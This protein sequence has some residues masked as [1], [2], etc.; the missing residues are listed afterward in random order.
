MRVCKIMGLVLGL[1]LN[2]FAMDQGQQKSCCSKQNTQ[3]CN[4]VAAQ[5]QSQSCVCPTKQAPV[6]QVEEAST[7]SSSSSSDS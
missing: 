1:S 2:I 6:Q 4:C 5:D 3:A 7:S